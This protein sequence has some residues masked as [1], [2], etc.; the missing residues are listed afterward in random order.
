MSQDPQTPTS[1][2]PDLVPARMLNEFAYCPRLA[3]LEWVQVD[4]ADSADTVEGR[5]HHRRVDQETGALPSADRLAD[6]EDGE[7]L[8][9]RSIYLSGP[10]VGLVAKIDLVEATGKVVTPVDYK[11]GS[12]GRCSYFRRHQTTAPLKQPFRRHS[13]I[14]VFHIS[15]AIRRRPH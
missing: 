11:R 13:R 10:N 8:H 12:R 14:A 5:F 2:I 6:A 1:E 3:Y 9:A 15:V 7:K 4:F